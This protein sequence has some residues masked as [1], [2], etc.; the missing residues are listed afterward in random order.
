[1]SGEMQA[2]S[3]DAAKAPAYASVADKA[4]I[5]TVPVDQRWTAR[6]VY[7]RLV[8]TAE[9]H[10][11]RPAISFQIKSG[12]KDKAE[13]LTWAE[14]RAETARAANLFRSLGVA[15][16]D[17][18]AYLLP[19]CNETVIALLAGATAGKVCPINPLLEPAQIA[20]LLR[21]T[22]AKVL[23]TLAPFPK[24]DVAE[25]AAKAVAEAPNVKTVLQVDLLRY[26]SFPLN[27]IVPLIRPK[28]AG[29]HGAKVL[30]FNAEVAKQS[31][32]PAFAESL[33]PARIGACFHTGGTT[34]MPKIAQHDHRG[35]LYNGWVAD[36]LLLSETDV[37][38]CPLPLFHVFAAYPILMA[39]LSSG[40]H[41][42]FPTPQGYRGEGVFDNFWK[43]IERWKATFMVTVPTAA[44]AL[45]Q[46]PVDAD[47]SSLRLAF[48]GSAPLPEALFNRFQD[49]TGV[50]ILEGYGM[51]EATCLVSA[52][53][54]DGTRKIGS[55][56]L[57]FP[58]TDVR[59]L[60]CDEVCNVLKE[61]GTDVI[62]EICISNPG[63]RPDG[64][65]TDP[66]RNV[67][68]YAEGRW[69]RTGDLGRIDAD[70]YLW[71]TG[72]AK[73]L[74][75]RGGHN[76]DPAMIEQALAQHPAVAFVGAIGQPDARAGELPCAY[77]ELASGHSATP[78]ELRKW[79]EERVSERAAHPKHVEVLDE[80][81]KT[82]V[83]KV[84]KP[85]LRK[86]A[87]ARV[88][89]QALAEAGIAAEITVVED[90][91]KGLV[92]QLSPKGAPL[93]ADKVREVLGSFPPPHEI[94]G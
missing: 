7:E 40:A 71:I 15:E 32:V 59:I 44:S 85:D 30:D 88:Y 60:H 6:S 86:R 68:L 84:F 87:I 38:I 11:K 35:M 8:Q 52:N 21:E 74:I 25:K 57:P 26:L 10:P 34:G 2:P 22:K 93:D 46:R 62:G 43:L 42:V 76:I 82:A 41:V 65:Y 18:V 20:A 72:R 51:T 64:T 27:L 29:G 50:K 91:K 24:T 90:R 36:E 9:A 31:D 55:V 70:G 33:D 54:V 66:E 49:A 67:G 17:A 13:T 89:A 45:M 48:C 58:Y 1:M 63:V 47:V 94:R 28:A 12:P 80:L 37:L 81:P 83:G 77:V 3:R 73:D 19:N 14:V 69:L 4:R 61:C 56:G 39:C 75:I 79:A 78:D 53:P 92:A 5:E 23:V 16:G